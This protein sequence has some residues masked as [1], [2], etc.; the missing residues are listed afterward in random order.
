MPETLSPQQARKLILHA[1]RLPA[2]RQTTK[3][4]SATL[5]AI[6]ALG[7]VQIDTISA[8]ER[9]HHHTL[10]N[11]TSTYQPQHLEQLVE[12]KQVFEYWAHAAAYLPMSDYRYTLVR[13]AALQ[14]GELAHWYPRNNK[15]M[16]DVLARITAEGPLMAKDFDK[17]EAVI[18]RK[19]AD[20]ASK[21]AKRAL[22]YLFMQG[23][24]M[25]AK[26]ANFHKVYDLTERVLPYS[27]NTS[28]PSDDAYF[29]F[30]ITRFLSANGLG[31]ASEIAYL[32]KN[33][34]S[35][36]QKELNAMLEEKSLIKVT[37][38]G[39]SYVTLTE[40]LETLERPIKRNKLHILSPFDNLLIQRKRMQA[41]FNFDY[42][43]ECYVPQAKRQYGYFSLPIL[44]DTNLVARMDCRVD[45]K[46]KILHVHHLVL[47]ANLQKTAAFHLALQQS[48]TAFLIFNQCDEYVL[49]KTTHLS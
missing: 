24:L 13:K 25:I 33:S 3:P 28:I 8:I 35:A 41:L 47:E 7:Y 4:I 11:R 15:L 37:V 23:D 22:E 17:D 16:A 40:Q 45:R 5:A 48:L 12:Q 36:I 14:S 43:L 26:R 49:H 44:W 38:A 19:P 42:L 2:G 6:E 20:W 1:Q 18:K 39:E 30:L 31:K 9:A 27:V 32:R 46:T 29:R 34:K 10:W 21:P